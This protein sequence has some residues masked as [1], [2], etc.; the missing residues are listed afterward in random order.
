MFKS[1][2]ILIL[3][4]GSWIWAQSDCSRLMPGLEREL[5]QN[6]ELSLLNQERLKLESEHLSQL[7]PGQQKIFRKD[8][9]YFQQTLQQCLQTGPSWQS[10]ACLKAALEKRKEKFSPSPSLLEAQSSTTTVNSTTT[11]LPATLPPDSPE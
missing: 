6:K 11:S 4:S 8:Q 2:A 9:Y 5:C 1:G 10:T 7:K 3:L